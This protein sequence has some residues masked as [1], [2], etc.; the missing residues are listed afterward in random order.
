MAAAAGPL[1]FSP[2]RLPF[3]RSSPWA[4]AFFSW[5]HGTR[6]VRRGHG[7]QVQRHN[8]ILRRTQVEILGTG[9]RL[10][11]GPGARLW[12]C[13]ITL[14][15]E[16]TELFIGANCRL[17]HARLSVEDQGSRLLIGAKTSVTGATLVSQEGRLLQVG[18]DCMIAQHAQVRNSDSHAIYDRHNARI[19]PPQDVVVGDHVWIGLNACI[20][21]GARI[22][23]GAMIGAH[24][25]VAGEIP[26]ACVAYGVPATP[27]YTAIHWDRDRAATGLDS[28]VLSSP[29]DS[30][31]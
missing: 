26:P 30:A 11:I 16:G 31:P 1:I 7:H 14:T 19:N 25:L 3:L 8:S 27:R 18:G 13:S 6:F 23:D 17:R 4:A 28:P 9:C 21:K 12:D 5:W 22:G 29:P 20:F 15:G 10:T 24:A 2:M